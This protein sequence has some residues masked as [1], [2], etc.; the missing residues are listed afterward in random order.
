MA[1]RSKSRSLG[2][3]ARVIATFVLGSL[4]YGSCLA[5]DAGARKT[6][7]WPVFI[8]LLLAVGVL[9]IV[10]ELASG[11]VFEPPASEPCWRQAVRLLLW[12]IV[13]IPLLGSIYWLLGKM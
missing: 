11:L 1:S 4:A 3:A 8:G 7:S 12:I 2:I 6:T 13:A 5:V 9:A 10:A